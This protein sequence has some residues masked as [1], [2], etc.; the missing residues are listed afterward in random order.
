M[1]LNQL[2]LEF[3]VLVDGEPLVPHGVQSQVDGTVSAY[4][5]SSVGKQFSL[6]LQN[7]TGLPLAAWVYMDGRFMSGVVVRPGT[8]G[9]MK[10]VPISSQHCR[11]FQFSALKLT[12]N[13]DVVQ[14]S[15]IDVNQIGLLE[16]KMFRISP[17]MTKAEDVKPRQIAEING[18]PERSKKLGSHSVTLGESQ[19]HQTTY[20]CNVEYLDPKHAPF[21]KFRVQYQSEDMLKARGII[22]MSAKEKCQE[23]LGISGQKRKRS[24]AEGSNDTSHSSKRQASSST[25]AI[26]AERLHSPSRVSSS[27]PSVDFI[28]LTQ[29]NTTTRSSSRRRIANSADDDVIDLTDEPCK[30]ERPGSPIR[31]PPSLNDDVIDLTDD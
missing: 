10:G 1:S 3:A 6:T 7:N 11:P 4:V 27:E 12:D 16:V 29:S 26:K 5:A 21:M 18:V 30:V 20:H 9:E 13:D 22:E 24:H 14:S 17:Y 19:I 31:V 8:R 2:G 25:K 28:D 15:A 23:E